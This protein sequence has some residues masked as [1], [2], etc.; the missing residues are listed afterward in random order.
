MRMISIVKGSHHVPTT[1]L[2]LFAVS[3]DEWPTKED[4]GMSIKNTQ[5]VFWYAKRHISVWS[6]VEL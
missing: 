1:K 3:K 5:C 2:I 4:I 6:N